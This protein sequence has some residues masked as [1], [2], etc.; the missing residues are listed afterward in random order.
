LVVSNTSLNH[1]DIG[2]PI[3]I[4]ES[5]FQP[6]RFPSL[7]D[8]L[9]MIKSKEYQKRK[10]NAWENVEPIE[11]EFYQTWFERRRANEPFDFERIFMNHSANHSNFLDPK[12]FITLDGFIVPYS[13]A[14]S[15]HVCSSCLEFFNILGSDWLVKYVVPC[16]G[17][18]LFGRLPIDQYFKVNVEN[19]KNTK[20]R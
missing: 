7:D 4:T 10:P 15:L 3:V 6:D 18:V 19:A 16:I 5:N 13:I 17:S 14:N 20:A 11:K 12:Y 9:K 2:N 1:L 8:I